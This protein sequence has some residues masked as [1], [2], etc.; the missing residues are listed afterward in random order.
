MH[1]AIYKE[2]G[3]LTAEGKTV[4]NKQEILKLLQAIRLPQQVAVIH[5][6]GHQR[7][8]ELSALEDQLAD[9]TVKS[10]AM[11]SPSELLLVT[12]TTTTSLPWYTKKNSDGQ[13][14]KG[15]PDCHKGDGNCP[16]E[17]S[18]SQPC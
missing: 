5:C 10:A 4:K 15:R 1:G 3:L 8:N 16:T 7:G 17:A 14:Q 6:Q 12:D 11:G 9:T 18:S 13:G 2:R